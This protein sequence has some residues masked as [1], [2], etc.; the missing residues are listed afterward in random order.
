MCT[1]ILNLFLNAAVIAIFLK[2]LATLRLNCRG[3]GRGERLSTCVLYQIS[4]QR[5]KRQEYQ[6]DLK[7]PPDYQLEVG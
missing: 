2:L 6:L 1:C 5:K 4:D 7:G 3:G